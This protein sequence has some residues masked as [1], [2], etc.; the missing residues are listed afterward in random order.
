VVSDAYDDDDS[1]GG[2][3]RLRLFDFARRRMAERWRALRAAVASTGG[4]FSLPEETTGYCNFTKQT[5]ATYPGTVTCDIPDPRTPIPPLS[6][7]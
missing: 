1:G 5:V 7:L 2:G 6:S 3:T 4:A